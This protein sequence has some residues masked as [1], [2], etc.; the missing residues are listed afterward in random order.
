MHTGK[1]PVKFV[2]FFEP[3]VA[4][5][6]LSEYRCAEAKDGPNRDNLL[7][8]DRLSTSNGFNSA[9]LDSSCHRH[10]R[11]ADGVFKYSYQEFYKLS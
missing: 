4:S 2:K 3:F 8:G 10:G 9:V 6:E 7:A 5:C 11:N 1:S